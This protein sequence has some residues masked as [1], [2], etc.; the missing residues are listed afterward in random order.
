MT[1]HS[2]HPEGQSQCVCACIE[3]GS[4]DLDGNRWVAHGS[5]ESD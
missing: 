5:D 1:S 2:H 3:D 4:F